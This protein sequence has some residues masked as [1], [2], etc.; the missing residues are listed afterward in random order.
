MQDGYRWTVYVRT[1][2][3]P[4]ELCLHERLKR[5]HDLR[6]EQVAIAYILSVA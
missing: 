2:H 1:V 5:L 4:E 3:R 6:D